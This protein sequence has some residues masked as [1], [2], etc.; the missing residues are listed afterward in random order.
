VL[1]EISPEPSDEE[2]A[3]IVATVERLIAEESER[4][5]R[6]PEWWASGV[7]ESLDGD[8]EGA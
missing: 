4:D 8:E 5:E 6:A 7:R 1:V 3:A 2:R